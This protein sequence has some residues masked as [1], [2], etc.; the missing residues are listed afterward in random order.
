MTSPEIIRVEGLRKT[1]RSGFLGRRQTRALNGVS[2]TVHAG[3]IFGVLGPNGAGKTTLLNILSTL[4]V[5]DEGSVQILG[6]NILAHPRR[7]RE[8]ANMSSGHANFPWSLTVR[9]ILNFYGMLYGL[10]RPAR[11]KKID[12]LL[13]FFELESFAT[14]AFQDLSTGTK[15]KVSLAKALINDPVLLFLDEPTVGLDP[16]IAQKLREAVRRL[17]RATSL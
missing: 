4:L 6:E 10:Q 13:V 3:E 11:R 12:E 17:A 1:F 9:E 16:D 8:R 5:P 14:R 7:L 2:L 15:Q